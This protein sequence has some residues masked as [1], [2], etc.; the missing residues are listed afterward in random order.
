[1]QSIFVVGLSPHFLD[2]GSFYQ[3]GGDGMGEGLMV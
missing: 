2:H 3:E 1:M